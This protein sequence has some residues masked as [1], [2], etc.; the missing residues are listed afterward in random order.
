[1]SDDNDSYLWWSFLLQTEMCLGEWAYVD[2]PGMQWIS[3]FAHYAI[4]KWQFV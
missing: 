3:Y 2:V 4:Q 1:M